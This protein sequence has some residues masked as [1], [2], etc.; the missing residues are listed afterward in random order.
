MKILVVIGYF[1]KDEAFGRYAEYKR[2][3]TERELTR[4]LGTL[5][6]DVLLHQIDMIQSAVVELTVRNQR[7]D[8]LI[9]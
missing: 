2:V 7:R 6:N 5:P 8:A 1:G 9:V 3:L 4:T